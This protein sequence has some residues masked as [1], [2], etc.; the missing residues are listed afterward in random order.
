M[1]ILIDLQTSH[2]QETE[3][4]KSAPLRSYRSHEFNTFTPLD[5]PYAAISRISNNNLLAI[6]DGRWSF[7]V[8]SAWGR[9]ILP[10]STQ[11]PQKS[12]PRNVSS[13]KPTAFQ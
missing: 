3:T 4:A 5:L 13:R 1:V 12:Q 9:G 2:D 8:P 11:Q 6:L 7:P 10:P